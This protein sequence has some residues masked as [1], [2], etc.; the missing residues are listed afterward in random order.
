MLTQLLLYIFGYFFIKMHSKKA[1]IIR[2]CISGVL[3]VF[4]FIGSIVLFVDE[5]SALLIGGVVLLIVSLLFL[6]RAIF[7]IKNIF[8]DSK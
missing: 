3:F 8:R 6:I 2:A 1:K 5:E 7:D 4:I